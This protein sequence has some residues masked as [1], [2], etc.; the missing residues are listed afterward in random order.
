MNNKK[1]KTIH[2]SGSGGGKSGG[3]NPVEAENDL[4]SSQ[5]A[6]IVDLLCEGEIG[7]LVNGAQSIF[8]DKTPLQNEDLTYNFKDVL[9][10]WR[11]GTQAQS[12]IAGNDSV[13]STTV[14]GVKI[15]QSS[16]VIRQ[17]TNV[18]LDSVNVTIYTPRMTVQD[19]STGDLNGSSVDYTIELQ[20]NGGGYVLKN[21]INITGKTITTYRRST[22]ILLTGSAPWDIRVTRITEDAPDSSTNNDIYFDSYTNIINTKLNYPNSALVGIRIDAKQFSRIPSRGYEVKL[23]KIKI[24]AN[25]DPLTREYTGIWDGTFIV[26]WSDNPAWCFYDLITND[27]YGLGK[28]IDT[29]L[30]DKWA[31]Y[32]I[33]QY[34]DELVLTG[35]LDELSAP[36]YEPRFTCNLYLQK[37]EEAYK[38]IRDMASIFRAMLFWSSNGISVV[39]DKPESAY[40]QFTNASVV[41]GLFNYE[42]SSARVRHTTALITWNDPN[43]AYKQKIEYVEDINGISKFGINEF[44]TVAMGC[45]SRGQAHR[46]GKWLLY[47]EN[48]ETEVISFKVGLEGTQIMPGVIIKT[49][50][51]NR[52]G[53]RYGGRIL[54]INGTTIDLDSSITLDS[55]ITYTISFVLPDGTVIDKTITTVGPIETSVVDIDSVFAIEPIDKSIW[56]VSSVNLS[57]EEWRVISVTENNPNT[58]VISALEYNSS[59]YDFTENDLELEVKQSTLLS[60][61]IEPVTGLTYEESLYNIGYGNFGT[62]INLSWDNIDNAVKYVLRWRRGDD[63]YNSEYTESNNI[64]LSGVGFGSFDFEVIAYN[65]LGASSPPVELLNQEILGVTAPPQD[66][67]NLESY[68]NGSSIVLKWGLVTDFDLDGYEIRYLE[69]EGSGLWTDASPLTELAKGTNITTIDIPDGDWLIMIKAVDTLGIY[70]VNYASSNLIFSSSFDIIDSVLFAPNFEG[71]LTN[72]VYHHTGKLVPDSQD[73]ANLDT[74]DTFD[75]TVPNPYNDCYYEVAEY[76]NGF[77]DINRVSGVITSALPPIDPVGSATPHFDIDYRLDAGSYDGFEKWSSGNVDFRYLKARVHVE[78]SIGIAIISEFKRIVD[79]IEWTQRAEDVIIDISGTVITYPLPF[80]LRPYI[81]ILVISAT[82]INAVVSPKTETQFTVRL[83]DSS[84]AAVAG[85]IDWKAIGV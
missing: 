7:G 38:V 21:T 48:N 28:F 55:G 60:A 2:I 81:D 37:R 22:N 72:M 11:D 83:F 12:P 35:F 43:D 61:T 52:A 66:V 18:E 9:V 46:L 49:I 4:I 58:Y 74:W 16:P 30:T 39:Q 57:P 59:K 44:Q 5:Y 79:A 10:D 51:A 31:L 23:L 24:P 32:E 33:A 40:S 15:L 36:T 53:S 42:G 6:Q 85:T 67:P 1:D 13:R 63:N 34:C 82:S 70:S 71:T 45:T 3:R 84:G 29:A 41:D 27:R 54:G 76:D 47:A 69:S 56:I 19:V 8:L 78:T 80:H 26:A 68:Q 17:I 50:D 25:Y 62:R 73:A 64:E 20:S 75:I 14:V 77:D 65:I